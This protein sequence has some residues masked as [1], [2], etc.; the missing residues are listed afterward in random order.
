MN[1][2]KYNLT[3][4][5]V[6]QFAMLYEPTDDNIKLN[7]T[8]PVKTN[9]EERTFAIGANVQYAEDDKPFLVAEVFCHYEIEESCWKELSHDNTSE[10]IIPAELMVTLAKIAIGALRGVIC[11]KTENTQFS[12]Y[13]LPLLEL[14][15]SVQNEDFIFPKL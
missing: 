13:Y 2:I 1:P 3:G 6:E 11:V 14:H 12:K 8:V 7:V 15:T 5:T 10:I 4:V 9:Y